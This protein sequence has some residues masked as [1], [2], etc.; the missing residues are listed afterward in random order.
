MA[1][2]GS[3]IDLEFYWQGMYVYNKKWK[4]SNIEIKITV[5]GV[6]HKIF[7]GIKT[8]LPPEQKQPL[9]LRIEND[10]EP[11]YQLESSRAGIKSVEISARI[12]HAN[13]K[14]ACTLPVFVGLCPK[15]Q[16]NKT[17]HILITRQYGELQAVIMPK[18][19]KHTNPAFQ[20]HIIKA[21]QRLAAIHSAS[22][23]RPK[24]TLLPIFPS[25]TCATS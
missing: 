5:E 11:F 24:D 6:T 18:E 17:Y 14:Y 2:I 20:A 8:S 9:V 25:P 16:T 7:A 13:G 21:Y 1:Q 12:L 3:S 4:I 23:N 15:I 19:E 10:N 22:V